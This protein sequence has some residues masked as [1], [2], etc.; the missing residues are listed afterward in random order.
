MLLARTSGG[1]TASSKEA[2]RNVG[3]GRSACD[4]LPVRA[5]G[6]N[7]ERKQTVHWP[8]V[9]TWRAFEASSLK[10]KRIGAQPGPVS[11]TLCG[12]GVVEP[13]RR[14]AVGLKKSEPITDVR[15]NCAHGYP[16]INGR[17]GSLVVDPMAAFQ[18]P[19]SCVIMMGGSTSR[20]SIA[21]PS[22]T[23]SR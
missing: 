9:T 4:R 16:R 2:L 6:E 3:Q 19:T 1:S 14:R 11:C 20:W 15:E 8:M 13:K 21:R 23:H 18:A 10:G 17:G 5:H 22:S 7:G 12:K